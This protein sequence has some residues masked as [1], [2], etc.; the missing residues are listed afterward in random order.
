MKYKG[1]LGAD[2]LDVDPGLLETYGARMLAG[3]GFTTADLTS[4]TV[5]AVIVNRTFVQG[6]LSGDA[7]GSRF[8]YAVSTERAGTTS[9][10]SYQIVGVIDDFPSF[11]PSPDSDGVPTVYHPAAPGT[12]HPFVLSVRFDGG[13]PAGF[14]DRFREIGVETD[15]AL[16]LR[17][18]VPL[19]TYYSDLRSIWRYLAWGIGLMTMA[20]LLLSAAGI[21]AMMSFTVAQRTRE[22]GLR[23]A[24]GASPRR[25]VFS[26]F[27]RTTRQLALGLLVGSLLSGVVFRGLEISAAR[28]ITLWVA[29]AA[30]MLIVGL[31]AA[32]G[33]LRR[34]LRIQPSE[35]LRAET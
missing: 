27:G 28:V 11:P 8:R 16:Q 31:L 10:V 32:F 1:T 25:I 20:V 18:V 29:V 19:S 15:P 30:I 12:V 6:F 33:P 3:R 5:N 34:G 7:L 14:V 23:A 21:Y 17:R 4:S 35:A 22:V 9:K 2:A 13:V 26:I 24:L